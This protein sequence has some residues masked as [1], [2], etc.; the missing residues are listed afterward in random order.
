MRRTSMAIFLM[1]AA[2][3]SPVCAQE[4]KTV[5]LPFEGPDVFCHILFSKGLQPYSTFLEASLDAK[6][7]MIVLFGDL[8]S[9]AKKLASA[10]LKRYLDAGGSILI[11]TDRR[12]DMPELSVTI[13]GSLV[14]RPEE[15]SFGKV[16]S[17]PWIPY[18]DPNAKEPKDARSHRL[19]HFLQNG[20]ATNGPSNLRVEP[21]SPIAQVLTFPRV[22][23]PEKG[24]PPFGDFPPRPPFSTG[25]VAASPNESPAAGR[26]VIIAGH[27][28]FMNGMMLQPGT[29]NLSFAI[30]TVQWLREGP[31]GS[32]RTRALMI[33]DGTA[34]TDFDRNLSPPPPPIPMPSVEMVNR[35]LRG[36]ED[37]GFFHWAFERVMGDNYRNVVPFLFGLGSCGLL[38]YG[39][40]KLLDARNMQD[41]SVPKMVG[42]PTVAQGE[43]R[44]RQRQRALYRQPDGHEEARLLARY[45][46]ACEFGSAAEQIAQG[47]GVE[48]HAAGFFWTRNRI[49]RQVEL[50]LQLAREDREAEAARGDFIALVRFLPRL[51]RALEDGTLTLLLDG[52]EVR[53]PSAPD[54]EATK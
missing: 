14:V 25:Y 52:K 38:L 26:T 46:L 3:A 15:M 23:P 22:F 24:R 49:R 18:L 54:A 2:L 53:K 8:G 11:A 37:E 20:I 34:I 50:V 43:P 47:G 17:C 45:W 51:S 9:S 36:L 48:I 28:V 39:G 6:S 32:A 27:G 5:T 41:S 21:G 13:S 7:S 42:A 40:K 1:W 10:D 4:N 30:N 12:F 29:D 31:K 16:R 19:F 33:V 35:L 44:S